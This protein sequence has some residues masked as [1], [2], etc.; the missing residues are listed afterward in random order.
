[1]IIKKVN[2]KKKLYLKASILKIL[3]SALMFLFFTIMFISCAPVSS[4]KSAAANKSTSEITSEELEEAVKALEES[5]EETIDYENASIGAEIKGA[6]PN[7][8]CT[9][10]DNYIKI[11][12]TNTSDF[13]WRKDGKNIVRVGYHYYG[14]DS[15]TAD[16]SEYDKTARTALPKDSKPGETATV[17]VLINDIANKENLKEFILRDEQKIILSDNALKTL[18][19]TNYL[20]KNWK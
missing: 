16:Y 9:D 20:N 4:N 11:E 18:I 13:T 10:K 6:I 3:V 2:S 8:L 15:G 14:Q 1:M 7:Y 19:S 12:I 17:E 5:K